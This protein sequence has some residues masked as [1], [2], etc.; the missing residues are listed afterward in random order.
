MCSPTVVQRGESDWVMLFV[1]SG[2]STR[3]GE[4]SLGLA[5][6]S[7]GLRWE[8]HEANPVLRGADL[9]A[10]SSVQTPHVLWDAEERLF[11]L[12]FVSADTEHD[13]ATGRVTR[14]S[15]LLS[16]AVSATGSDWEVLP[17]A[18]ATACRS[19]CVARTAHGYEMWMNSDPQLGD[20]QRMPDDHWI[21]LGEK[22]GGAS[23]GLVGMGSNV[24]RFTS[25]NG[26]EW[27]RDE[28]PTV[29]AADVGE[30]SVIY[31]FVM[32]D[33]G[34]L[35]LFYGCHRSGEDG[36]CFELFCSTSAD[37]GAQ[38]VHHAESVLPATRD[39]CDWDGRY[40]STPHVMRDR[41]GRLLLYYSARDWGTLYAAGDGTVQ[42]D[43]EGVY[44]HIGVAIAGAQSGKL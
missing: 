43:S 18:L 41:Q 36:G 20:P 14:T 33:G 15:A 27:S 39:Q 7:D 40:T 30:R 37:G 22:V 11:R 38:W 21:T 9:P 12:W 32:R 26:L 16:H 25:E 6:S 1:G 17:A 3:G 42:A 13:R 5:F 29:T 28:A 2:D 4:T 44:R 10:G 19:P 31:P 35:A 24:Y 23:P 34:S 8:P